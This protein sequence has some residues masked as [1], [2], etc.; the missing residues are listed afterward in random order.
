MMPSTTTAATGDALA[1]FDPETGSLL[2]RLLFRYRA[3]IVLVCVLLTLGLGFK[4]FELRLNA[5]FER[6]IPAHHPFIVNFLENKDSLSG[7]GNVLRVAVEHVDGSILD[8]GYLDT[9][10]KVNDE[11]F[12][13]P[14]VDQPYMKSLWTPAT[15]WTG[16][17]EEGLVGGPVIDDGYDGSGESLVSVRKNIERSGEIGQLVAPDFASSIVIVPLLETVGGKK[18]DYGELSARL[19]QIRQRYESDRVRIHITGFAKVVG[20]L[21]DGVRQVLVFFAIAIAVCSGVLLWYT[22]CARST[23]I[24]MICSVVAVV[25]QLGLLSALGL[26]L[27]P[28]SVLVP[29][30]VFAIGMSHGAQKMNGIMQDIGR[31]ASKLAAARLTF[32]RL[33]LTGLTALL[34]D[35]V[36]FAVLMIV[37]IGV[38]QDLALAASIGVGGLIVTNLVLTPI[39][40]SYAGVS[41]T[42]AVR[43]LREEVGSAESAGSRH[44]V[45]AFLDRFTTRRWAL[46]TVM[47]A[48]MI[49]VGAFAVSLHL[50]IGDTDPGAP[51]LRPDSRY[52]RDSQFI[53]E[54]YAASSDIYVVMVKTQ[55]N[56]CA[57]YET[58][59]KMDALEWEL[60][61]LPGV[62]GTASAAS[63]SKR[64]ASGLSEGS[65]K[66]AELPRNQQALNS[67]MGQTP[68]EFFNQDCD[69]L[70]VYAYL[71]DHKAETLERVVRAVEGFATANDGP[72]VKF[73]SAAGNAGIE[74]ATN[75]VV[76]RSNAQM[77]LLIYLSVTVLAFIT[78]RSW[79][80]VLCAVIPLALTSVLCEALMVGLGIGVK[81]ATL[82]VIALGVGIGIDYALYI[83]SVTLAQLKA[84]KSLSDAYHSALCFT[85][86]VVLLTGITLGVAVGTWAFSPIKFQA[87]MGILLAFMFVLNMIGALVL[88]PA[89]GYF[90][91]SHRA[92][93]G[94]TE[95]VPEAVAA[96]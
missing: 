24:V 47:V 74:A 30:L 87:D 20:D 79:R 88:L 15:R 19:E 45:W 80:G 95:G 57:R 36:G 48:A 58:L 27:D 84:G 49:G 14:G 60:Q 34:A 70:T 23:A 54:R 10:K 55:K 46:P 72:E 13:L 16:V 63:I 64:M 40:L 18:L 1:P 43:S 56:E 83:L 89:L 12:V 25:W 21:I 68:R 22:R 66:W 11:L 29:F 7:L 32:R 26:E 9:L 82:P 50:K 3:L 59:A 52:N 41:S 44:P 4:A 61:Q 35:V 39:L 37:D 71:K 31:G 42:A 53:V 78:F 62:A 67:G 38:I 90:L 69:L 2:E 76:H 65:L 51:E 93:S 5:S 73:L 92:P 6:M 17:T 28:Y 33:F 75:I 77:L 8:A 91:L 94:Q 85:G 86:R 96:R 81:V